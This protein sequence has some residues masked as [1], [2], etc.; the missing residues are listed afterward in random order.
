VDWSSPGIKS[1]DKLHRW[2]DDYNFHFIAAQM[3]IVVDRW[4][5]SD[6]TRIKSWKY[7]QEEIDRQ[8]Q[9]D[10]SGAKSDPNGAWKAKVEAQLAGRKT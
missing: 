1:F 2:L 10:R 6:R 7:F 8:A 3:T 5:R 9:S 4:R